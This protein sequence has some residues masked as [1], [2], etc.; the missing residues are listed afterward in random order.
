MQLQNRYVE[1]KNITL[2]YSHA[3]YLV[4][5]QIRTDKKWLDGND[6]ADYK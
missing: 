4:F 5:S 1:L 2:S 3:N 6:N